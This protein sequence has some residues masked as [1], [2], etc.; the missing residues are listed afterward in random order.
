MAEITL[1]AFG[2]TL[3]LNTLEDEFFNGDM[4]WRLANIYVPY[5]ASRVFDGRGT[6]VDIGAGVGGFSL[7]FARAFPDVRMVCFEPDPELF[8][9]LQANIRAQALANVEALNFA[10]TAEAL[11]AEHMARYA[12]IGGDF[13]AAG[14]QP[15]ATRQR[16]VTYTGARSYIEPH[17]DD[18]EGVEGARVLEYACIHA[19][20][21]RPLKPTVL[22]LI[23]PLRE[24]AILE[25]FKSEPVEHIVAESWAHIDTRKLFVPGQPER[26][27]YVRRAGSHLALRRDLPPRRDVREGLDIVIPTYNAAQHIGEC[28]ASLTAHDREDIHVIVVDDGSRDGCGEL[29]NTTFTNDPRVRV[30]RKPN[31]GCAS[32]RNYGRRASNA[33]HIAFVDADDVVDP[34]LFPKLLE[35]ARYTSAETVQAGFDFMDETDEGISYRDSYEDTLFAHHKKHPFIDG[36]LYFNASA[37]LL[38]EGQP[39]IWRRIYRRDFLD[40]KRLLFPEHIRAF[41]DQIFQMLSLYYSR[42]I[43]VLEGPRYHYRQHPMQD[44]KQADE[45]HFYSLEMFRLIIKRGLQEGWSSFAPVLRSYVNTVN[46]SLSLLSEPLKSNYVKGAARL[47]IYME[48]A[49]GDTTL[50]DGLAKDFRHPEFEFLLGGFRLRLKNLHVNYAFAYMDAVE[51]QPAFVRAANLT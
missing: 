13:N 2:E 43:P 19:S 20:A 25:V 24:E 48:K 36:N 1:S 34:D 27:F 3:T 22:K 32:A 14:L 26:Q 23:A 29:V 21:L 37:E 44:I 28:V 39:T 4:K 49:V 18:A 35:L 8:E 50:M 16:F 33:T 10:V 30:I 5:F 31:G 38:M 6:V 40:N 45:R 41:D 9:L 47:W 51:M 42:N 12:A 7:P 17:R 11:T 15:L 46:W